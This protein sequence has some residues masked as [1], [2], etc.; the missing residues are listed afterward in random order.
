MLERRFASSSGMPI[1]R[2]RRERQMISPASLRT[3]RNRALSIFFFVVALSGS[4]IERGLYGCRG[5]RVS[6]LGGRGGG[7]GGGGGGGWGVG[8]GSDRAQR[9]RSFI[10]PR[11]P[12]PD[13]RH[14]TPV[15]HSPLPTPH[16]P[17]FT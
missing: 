16:P 5:S 4:A 15:S 13:S 14:P 10:D 11:Q 2:R 9:S 8:R 1:A 3:A 12:T 6:A 7:G 17:W